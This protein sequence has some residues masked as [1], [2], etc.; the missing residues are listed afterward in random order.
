MRCFL[1]S[2]LAFM[3]IGIA[4]ARDIDRIN[5]AVEQVK[6]NLAERKG[7]P[8]Q[9]VDGA[10]YPKALPNVVFVMVTYRQFPIAIAPPEGLGSSN[11]FAIVGNEKP[12]R[13]ADIKELEAFFRKHLAKVENTA[14]AKDALEA[15]LNLAKEFRQDGMFRFEVLKKEFAANEGKETTVRGRAMVVQGGNGEVAAT[16]V[17]ADGKL[18]KA[19]DSATIRPGPRPICQATKLLDADPIVRKMAEQDLLIM[20]R[21]A[22][23]YLGEQ[24]EKA[25]LPLR[26]A[27]DALRKRIE[28]NGW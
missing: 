19:T 24:R 1:A 21:A 20:G 16:L 3:G 28:T 10:E 2:A 22:F 4:S 5:P 18:Q 12:Q 17:F 23:P 26:E 13:L 6:K 7:P 27:I 8:P 14:Q 15:W 25:A 11:V 9:L